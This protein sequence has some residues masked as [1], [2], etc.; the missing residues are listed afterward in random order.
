[1]ASSRLQ[2]PSCEI[3]VIT[4]SREVSFKFPAPP[5][6][7]PRLSAWGTSFL[8]HGQV[9]RPGLGLEG[10]GFCQGQSPFHAVIASP[11]GPAGARA[12]RASFRADI[13]RALRR[14]RATV[15]CMGNSSMAFYLDIMIILDARE[16]CELFI[17]LCA[18]SQNRPKTPLAQLPVH[19]VLVNPGL[20]S[21]DR[22]YSA[23]LMVDSRS[24]IRRAPWVL[25]WKVSL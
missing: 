19:I 3:R 4:R 11:G 24:T 13:F 12:S 9:L 25:S 6:S 21:E 23:S 1:M 18:I 10:L 2:G 15:P 20:Q 17:V 8:Q 22:D 14:S 7:S 16:I 5:P